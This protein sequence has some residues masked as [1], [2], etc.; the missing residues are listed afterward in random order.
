MPQPTDLFCHTIPF[1]KFNA[2]FWSALTRKYWGSICPP[3][4][5]GDNFL[6]AI[7]FCE[8]T[9]LYGGLMIK[10]CQGQ[11]SFTNSFSSNLNTVNLK[12]FANHEVIYTWR[13]NPDYS[14][15]LWKYLY[16]KL[17]FKRFQRLHRV[18]P[19]LDILFVNLNAQIGDCI[20]K[21]SSAP[22]ASE[23]GNSMPIKWELTWGLLCR[24]SGRG[25]LYMVP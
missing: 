17:I 2:M 22:Y 1:S 23:L 8:G 11:R 19:D 24:N 15:E 5:M 20:R 13:Q 9:V 4:Q 18:Q 10:S 14:T 3:W 16:L 25:K 12:I 21:T 7:F 6:R